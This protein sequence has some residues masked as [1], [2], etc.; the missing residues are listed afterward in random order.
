MRIVTLVLFI[1]RSLGEGGFLLDQAF[2]TLLNIVVSLPEISG[3]GIP[4]VGI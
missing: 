4:L 2:R 3:Y 1:R